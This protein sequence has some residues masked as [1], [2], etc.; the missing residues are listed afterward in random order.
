MA[1]LLIRNA[2][3]ILTCAVGENAAPFAG[4]NQSAIG[5][6]TGSIA[7]EGD[8]I[9]AIGKAADNTKAARV[10]DA[11]GGVVLP[12][13]V[14]CHT[15][16]VFCGHRADEFE[17]RAK[18]VSYEAIARNGGGIQKST[19][20]LREATDEE[21]RAAVLRHL[22]QFLDGGTTTIEAKSGYGLSL[23]HELR[24][25][26]ALDVPHAVEVVRTCLAGHSVP[27]EYKS[28]RRDYIT[29]VCEEIFPAVQRDQLAEYCDVF[30]EKNVFTFEE[31]QAILDAGKR[32]GM[33]G[34]V[35]ADQLSRS[36]GARLACRVGAITADHLEYA[37]REDAVAMREAGVTAVLLPGANYVLNQDQRAPARNMINMQCPVAVATDF[38]PGS[39]PI[40]SMPLTLNLACVRFGMTVAE[41]IIG[42]TINAAHTINRHDKIGSLE[43][44]KQAD[45]LVCNV[46][47]YREIAYWLG[48]NPITHV[49]KKGVLVREP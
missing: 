18:G 3:Q 14:D 34:R 22:D 5:L 12:G 7:I 8:R 44:G 10:I 33:R 30:V 41:A 1:D 15:H 38:N 36:G 48:R 21:L 17:L 16:A 32:H 45:V 37:T 6:T 25:L 35:H 39:A 23:E 26:R 43:L 46:S 24:A 9:M 19:G 28:K 13:F 29:L 42:A 27:P 2:S 47:D 40:Q 11:R 31:G 49:I 20:Q 4:K